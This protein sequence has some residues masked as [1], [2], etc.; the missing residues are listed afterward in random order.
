MNEVNYTIA[1]AIII[2]GVVAA[3]VFIMPSSEEREQRRIEAHLEKLQHKKK[4]KEETVAGLFSDDKDEE[5]QLVVLQPFVVMDGVF[6]VHLEA[7]GDGSRNA[8]CTSLPIVHD[9]V[10]TELHHT[11]EDPEMQ[12]PGRHLKSYADAVRKHINDTFG[13]IV[14]STVILAYAD[15]QTFNANYRRM[16][17]GSSK[18]CVKSRI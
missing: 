11:S 3:G 14:V 18:R 7:T 1:A 9:A 16:Q 13:Q 2:P 15:L 5:T 4:A 17:T 6:S 8:L 12:P 10:L